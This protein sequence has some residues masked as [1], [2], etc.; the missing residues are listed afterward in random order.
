MSP[1]SFGNLGSCFTKL[2]IVSSWTGTLIVLSFSAVHLDKNNNNN[3]NNND[4]N[5]NNESFY[6][7]F[8][9][10][11]LIILPGFWKEE[12]FLEDDELCNEGAL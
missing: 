10:N 9:N 1:A 5:N 4:N 7:K 12:D 6:Y 3:N 8:N 11:V 2:F